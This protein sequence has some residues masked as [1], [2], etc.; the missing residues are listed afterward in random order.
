MHASSR[1]SQITLPAPEILVRPANLALIGIFI[2]INLGLLLILDPAARIANG[3]DSG[4]W[5]GPAKALIEHGTLGSIDNPT[6]PSADRG[7]IYPLLIAGLMAVAGPDYP[8]LLAAVQAG[9]LLM[10]ALLTA[11]IAAAYRPDNATLALGLVL[12]NP[13]LLGAAQ[14][15]QS[16]TVYVFILT[17]MLFVILRLIEN[18]TTRNAIWLGALT[19]VAALI[20]PEG[21]FLIVCIPLLLLVIAAVQ[22]HSENVK[23]S[24]RQIGMMCAACVIASC[25][26]VAPWILRNAYAGI[27][28][29]LNEVQN[30]AHYAWGAVEQVTVTQTSKTFWEVPKIIEAERSRQLE[31]FKGQHPGASK[32][33]IADRD[34]TNALTT[35]MSLPL[36]DHLKTIVKAKAEFLFAGGAGTWI[37]LLRGTGQTPIAMM[38]ASGANSYW[39]GWLNAMSRYPIFELSLTAVALGYVLVLRACAVVGFFRTWR[40][41]GLL[42]L[43]LCAEIA[44]HAFIQPYYGPSRFRL[45]VE[46]AFVLLAILAL[47]VGRPKRAG[48]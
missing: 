3:A 33:E 47:P 29:R 31:K 9:L 16:E 22:R 18:F 5:Y 21:T 48:A 43:I 4:T 30:S 11:Q 13:N 40:T 7:P 45:P 17:C 23:T 24:W 41:N 20:R 42:L 10:V 32:K 35:L 36:I 1:P 6:I 34:F 8:A 28:F 39:S 14:L 2:A 27:G 15:V 37:G 44:F 46:P 26:V 38:K 25:V 12:L 19:G